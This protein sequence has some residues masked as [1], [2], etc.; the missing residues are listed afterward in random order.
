MLFDRLLKKRRSVVAKTVS[1]AS[2][3]EIALG[4]GDPAARLDAVRRLASL[5]HLRQILATDGDAGVREIALGRYRNL[6]SGVEE[7]G[8][9]LAERLTE[10]ARIEDPRIVEHLALEGRDAEARLAAIEHIASPAVLVNC[11]LHDP[12]A[13][14][15][16]AALARLDDR[17]SLEH[18]V[19]RIG[20][21]DTGIY[22]E[23]RERLRRMAEQEERPRRLRAQ[24]AE[25][26][27]RAEG[28][29][30]LEHWSQDRA[31]LD[32]LDDQW[33]QVGAEADP[34]MR[35][36]YQAARERFLRAYEAHLQATTAEIAAKEARGA[37]RKAREAL[38][39]QARGAVEQDDEKA[40]GALREGLAV[41]WAAL[42]RG[43]PESEQ[44]ALDRRFEQTLAALDTRLEELAERRK[45]QRRLARLKT[46]LASRLTESG[47]LDSAR[48][49][50]ELAEL[51]SLLQTLGQPVNEE[52]SGISQELEARLRE[53]RKEAEHRIQS[54]P[55]RITELEGML[56]S[57]EL[58]RAEPLHEDIASDLELGR[59]SGIAEDAITGLNTRLRSLSGRLRDLQHWRRWGTN[60]HRAA[61]CEAMEALRNEDLPL[62]A[63]AERFHVL[64]ADWK[65]LDPSVAPANRSL[66]T[67]FHQASEAVLE[68]CR[69]Y[70][71]AEAAERETN[72]AARENVCRQL[73]EFLARVDWTRIDWRRV[74]HAERETRQAWASI[75][76]TDDRQRRPLDRRF[77]R[78][79]KELDQRLETERERNQAFKQG[80]IA[81]VRSL[82]ESADLDAAI[83]ETKALQRQWHT[84]VPARQ[85]DENRLWQDFRAACDA[86]FER[87]AALHQAH[88]AELESNLHA[89]E[90]LREEAEALLGGPGDARAL[91]STLRELEHRWRD[92]ESLPVPRQAAG[93][94]SR[95]WQQAREQLRDRI[96]TL[97]AE[98][99]RAALEL[100]AQRAALCESVEH[101]VLGLRE[102]EPPL[103]LEATRKDWSDLPPLPDAT[104][105]E[106]MTTRL[107]RALEAAGN[108]EGLTALRAGLTRNQEDRRHLCLAL[109]IAAGVESPPQ[110]NQ[111][112]LRLQ[113]ERLAERMAEGEGDRLKGVPEL[114]MEWY[115][116]GPAPADPG[117]DGRVGRV[118]AAWAASPGTGL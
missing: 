10:I 54:L 30:R 70:L 40:L 11:V 78:A 75:G 118:L 38:I 24:C 15:R 57:G 1:Q 115:R 55:E 56:E 100:L 79:I 95:R 82:A 59:R 72:R 27:E 77:R 90:A 26:C 60:Q 14:N 86:V 51:R 63:V 49:R 7:A 31:L 45:A 28:L 36:R 103:D 66:W 87:R 109:E 110:L 92:A 81:R 9:P 34:P 18:I 52:I 98:E 89:R 108:P 35:E 101:Q 33:T 12:R 117:L 19:R 43:L 64:Q 23:A 25:L 97:E 105:Q 20:K 2:L 16:G 73:E 111:E 76:P 42:E 107:D 32:H 83:E 104:L 46:R 88:R 74:L 44:G 17:E 3:A 48:I 62:A 69:P 61:L 114:L 39:T 68:R 5:P 113:V 112:R 85:R 53:Q 94:L 8:I 67:R 71:E 6:L 47:P 96:Q 21:K 58:K 37:E 106:A 99:R 41:E 91:A 65:G 50:G 84:T 4:D 116:C 93:A 80:L 13:A 29:G 22:R 102:A